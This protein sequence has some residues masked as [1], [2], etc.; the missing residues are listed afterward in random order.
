MSS[1]ALTTP[2]IERSPDGAIRVVMPVPRVG[3]V[4][5]FMTVWLIGW[6][7]GEVSAIRGLFLTG[8]T[9]L[10]GTAFLLFWLVGWTAG[11][12]FAAF[13]LLMTLGGTEVLTVDRDVLRRRAEVFGRWGLSWRY[14]MERCS[15]FRPTGEEGSKSFL[16]FDY[17][18]RK[19]EKTVRMG[20][21]LSED[22]AAEIAEAVWAAFPQLMPDLERRQREHTAAEA[23][24]G[25][26]APAGP[27]PAAGAK[28]PQG[29]AD[30]NRPT[31]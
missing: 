5:A 9:F 23:R 1:T 31:V 4:A 6:L 13:T 21:G 15:N 12:I 17:A 11:G 25:A 2:E 20:S 7:A 3:C 22:R 26:G 29:L 18:G 24:A 16:S 8:L 10:P 28:P 27:D 30:E 19:A 14:E